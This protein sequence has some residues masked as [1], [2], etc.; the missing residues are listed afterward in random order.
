[1]CCGHLWGQ[2]S[3]LTTAAWAPFFGVVQVPGPG[4]Q[5]QQEQLEQAVGV[6]LS[7]K[8][9]QQQQQQPSQVVV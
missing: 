1:M 7:S 5:Q 6:G 8:Q 9:R 2:L 4:Q 3:A